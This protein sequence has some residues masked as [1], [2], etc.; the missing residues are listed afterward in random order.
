M[1]SRVEEDFELELRSLPGVLNVGMSHRENGDVEVVTLVVSDQDIIATR[2]VASQIA[3]LYFPEAAIVV[4]D[5]SHVPA[6]RGGGP[7]IALMRA[8]YDTADGYCEVQLAYNGRVGVGR[9]GSSGPMIGGAEATLAALRNLG[10]DIPFRLMTVLNV[11]NGKDWPV[12]VTLRS[13]SNDADR[14]GIALSE[15]DLL[16]AVKATLDSLN[17]YLSTLDGRN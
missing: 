1:M 17:R 2:G 5:V 14:Y 7:R 8:D 16:S 12:V 9:A 15:D 6:S 4:D 10:Y 3:S 13:L 11:T